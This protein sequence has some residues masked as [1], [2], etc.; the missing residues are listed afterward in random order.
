MAGPRRGRGA[1]HRDGRHARRSASRG[2][3]LKVTLD[4]S[5][6][7]A[8]LSPTERDHAA[9]ASLVSS[10]IERG[11]ALHQPGLFV[12]EV[13]ATVARR[14]RNRALATD[15]GRATLEVPGLIVHELDH[16]LAAEA[17]EI[18]AACALRGADA[19]YVATAKR[20]NATLVTLDRELRER[21]DPVAD[22]RTPGEW[23]GESA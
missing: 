6:W 22:V 17:A 5:V 23:I 21:A 12:I 18:A 2:S 16:E 10:L 20:M 15:A 4:A 8:A 14:T 13:C 9:C 11:V 7:L 1:G 19:V 3:P